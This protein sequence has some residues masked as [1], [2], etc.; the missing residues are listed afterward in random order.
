[1]KHW[2]GID[3]SSAT[4]DFALLDEHGVHLESLQVSNGRTAVMTLRTAGRNDT[5]LTPGNA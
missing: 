1:M 3:V 2:I 5:E 4:L